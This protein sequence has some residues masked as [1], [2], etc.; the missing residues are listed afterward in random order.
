MTVTG[1]LGTAERER[2][3]EREICRNHNYLR[4]IIH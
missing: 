1:R 4:T 2:E 3:R